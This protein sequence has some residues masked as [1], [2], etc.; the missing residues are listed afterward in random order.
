MGSMAVRSMV[1]RSMTVRSMMMRTGRGEPKN[2]GIGNSEVKGSEVGFT[3]TGLEVRFHSDLLSDSVARVGY[4]AMY[5][6]SR[7]TL[8]LIVEYG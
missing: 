4:V 5:P 8:V 6:S 3:S 7:D 1:M 2:P